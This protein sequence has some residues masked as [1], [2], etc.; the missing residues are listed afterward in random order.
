MAVTG[1]VAAIII[2]FRGLF[3]GQHLSRETINLID[4]PGNGVYTAGS[5]FQLGLVLSDA[6]P[7]AQV[8]WYF[9]DE[10]VAGTSV[11]LPAG[12]HVIEAHMT[13]TTGEKK[14]VELTIVAQ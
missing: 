10:S 11:T 13:L 14:I 1:F 2:F 8:E 3:F 4:N 12:T 5:T 6:Q 9:D 7:V